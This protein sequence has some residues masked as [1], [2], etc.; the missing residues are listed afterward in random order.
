MG[1]GSKSGKAAGSVLSK[2]NEELNNNSFKAAKM[3]AMNQIKSLLLGY[4]IKK[5]QAIT[6]RLYL[7]IMILN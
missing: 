6:K 4:L 1:I 7:L 2:A 5:V 3:R